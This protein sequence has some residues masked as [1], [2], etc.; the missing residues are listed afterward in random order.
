MLGVNIYDNLRLFLFTIPFFSLIASFSLYQ[1]INN[2]NYSPKKIIIPAALMIM[3]L[4]SFY[5]F[6]SLTPYQY[7]YINY[8]SLKLSNANTKWE[9]DYWGASYK[10]L[11]L[12]IK[13]T[14]SADEIKNLKITNCSGDDTLLYYLFRNLGK[15]FI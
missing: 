2:F 4:L 9:H 6:V 15:K 5:R 1:I 13:D 11:V 12:K 3:F 10:E 14:Y 8:S 7:D